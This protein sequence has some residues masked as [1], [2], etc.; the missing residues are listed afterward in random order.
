[1]ATA[2]P[3]I[4]ILAAG[5]GTRMNSDLP[6]V[7]HKVAG[8]SMLGHVLA[9]AETIP[10]ARL[11]V[12]IGPGMDE[13]RAEVSRLSPA[14]Q[15]FVQANQAGTA[16]AVLAARPALEAHTGDVVVLYADTPLINAATLK[17]L[18]TALD[19]GAAVTVL[20]FDAKDPTGYGRLV[21]ASG[22]MLLAIREHKD[23][24]PE[25]L[26]ITLCNSGVIAFR[27][28]NLLGVLGKIGN[29]NAKQEYY[30][31]DAVEIARAEGAH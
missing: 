19:G 1:M 3:L 24:S 20:G 15:V 31:T 17:S 18:F 13:V 9:L 21:T 12:V 26:K 2:A 27:L 14:A 8:R 22:S 4:V 25:E 28:P 6:K 11:A 23:S 16:D 29:A 5:K 30:L 7:L 10:D